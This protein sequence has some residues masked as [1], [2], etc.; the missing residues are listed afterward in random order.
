M[1]R[2]SPSPT[3][4]DVPC[5]DSQCLGPTNA[6]LIGRKG[7]IQARNDFQRCPGHV[8]R[9]TR[10]SFFLSIFSSFHPRSSLISFFTQHRKRFLASACSRKTNCF[11]RM[12]IRFSST[13]SRSVT[14]VID[15]FPRIA[16][17]A[18]RVLHTTRRSTAA[19]PKSTPSVRGEHPRSFVR[20]PRVARL[21]FLVKHI[22]AVCAAAPIII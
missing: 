19:S 15:F 12:F 13:N 4:P 5:H 18:S 21:F 8:P 6:I 10:L 2:L 9:V 14:S 16:R 11:G 3:P 20:Y 17:G 1:P 22:A 7:G